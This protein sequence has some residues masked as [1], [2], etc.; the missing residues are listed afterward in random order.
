MTPE[1]LQKAQESIAYGCIKYADL[2]HNRNHEYVFSFD[3]MLEDKGN[4]AVYLLYAYTRIRS[5]ARN[6]NFTP[7]KIQELAK[8]TSVSLDHEKEWKLGKTLLRFPEVLAKISKDLY[9]HHLC[10]FVYEIA[11]TFTEF[12]D[13]CY[14]IEKDSSGDIVKVNHGRILLTEATALVMGKCF[15]ILGLKP[16]S[17]M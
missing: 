4:T 3:K 14:C 2:S 9:L 17:K 13:S 16:V 15:D 8:N 7:E 10:E 11:T 6:A 5:I 1:E 12:Y